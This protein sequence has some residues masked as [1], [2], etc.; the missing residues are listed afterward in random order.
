MV[1]ES[2]N[3][4]FGSEAIKDKRSNKWSL[5]LKSV[6]IKS[7]KLLFFFFLVLTQ[8]KIL[9][10]AKKNLIHNLIVIQQQN[11]TWEL[12]LMLLKMKNI[13]FTLRFVL[14]TLPC[15]F[16]LFQIHHIK[17]KEYTVATEHKQRCHASWNF[18]IDSRI[19]VKL[20]NKY[21]INKLHYFFYVG[22]WIL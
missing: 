18:K 15:K 3:C 20:Y 13:L 17:Y 16:I 8:L 4:F 10:P 5:I 2:C 21:K 1:L 12:I 11:V 14:E 9:I 7:P 19:S 22:D 6:K